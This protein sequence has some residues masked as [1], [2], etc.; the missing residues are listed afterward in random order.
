MVVKG[1]KR[2]GKGKAE[3]KDKIQINEWS[4]CRHGCM[5]VHAQVI[6]STVSVKGSKLLH[7]EKRKNETP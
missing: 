6:G 1:K 5:L 2:Q 4:T 3:K 7:S